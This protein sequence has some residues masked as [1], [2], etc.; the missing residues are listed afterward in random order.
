MDVIAVYQAIKHAAEWVR[1]N[2]RPYLIEAI[3]Y[4]FRGHSMADPGKY[5]A[6]A[7]VEL[8]KAR[9]P[10]LTFTK[11]IIEEE[12]ANEDQLECLKAKARVIVKEAVEFAEQSPWPDDS[13]VTADI[14]VGEQEVCA[15][16]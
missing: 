11:R 6:A 1:E 12:V 3:T 14:F 13:E 5:R 4:R 15:W 7:E 10:I 8:W 16:R 2:S 9:D